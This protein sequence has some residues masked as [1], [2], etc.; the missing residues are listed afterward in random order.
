M[1]ENFQNNKKTLVIIG[2]ILIIGFLFLFS[3]RGNDSQ[4]QEEVGVIASTTSESASTSADELLEDDS[5][6]TVDQQP[7]GGQMAS[8][9][10]LPELN[11]EDF[12]EKGGD[13]TEIPTASEII[14]LEETVSDILPPDPDSF[15]EPESTALSPDEYPELYDGTAESAVSL[16]QVG[17]LMTELQSLQVQIN[18]LLSNDTTIIQDDL[19]A[20]IAALEA[21]IEDLNSYVTQL[22]ELESE[23]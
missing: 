18:I 13:N 11:P 23:L 20:L 15:P 6:A 17:V 21:L 7:L 2:I 8:L 16:S 10:D 1:T 22:A 19:P 14:P 5:V 9:V 3:S 12:L 4:T